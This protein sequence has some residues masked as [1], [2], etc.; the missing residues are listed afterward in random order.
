LK[1]LKIKVSGR[2]QGVG[3]RHAASTMARYQGIKGF[4]KNLNDGSVYIEAEAGDKELGDFVEWCRKGPDFA[5][6]ARVETEEIPVR[7]EKM[8]DVRT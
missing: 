3:F 1:R 6:V 2:V 4:I 8:F 7:N 5:R